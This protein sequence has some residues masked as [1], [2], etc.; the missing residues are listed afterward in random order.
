[1]RPLTAE[2]VGRRHTIVHKDYFR[3]LKTEKIV[4]KAIKKRSKASQSLSKFKSKAQLL[5]EN[6]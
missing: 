5:I 4:E 6:Y 2:S 3:V 1:M